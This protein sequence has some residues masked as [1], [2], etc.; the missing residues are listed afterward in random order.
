MPIA[1]RAGNGTIYGDFKGLQDGLPYLK[2]L[3]VTAVWMTP[4]HPSPAYHGYQY[5]DGGSTNPLL[6]SEAEF[7]SFVHQAHQS[8]IKVFID[9]VGYGIGGSSSYFTDAYKNPNSAYSGMFKWYDTAHSSYEGYSYQ[10]WN[11]A[12][13]SFA[14]W[15]MNDPRPAQIEQAWARKWLN[16]LYESLTDAGVDGFRLDHVV[17][18]HDNYGPNGLGYTTAQF[19]T[20][21]LQGL[22]TTYPNAKFFGEQSEWADFGNTY[23]PP[24]DATFTK[25]LEFALRD[26][27]S[28]GDKTRFVTTITQTLQ[29]LGPSQTYLATFG[30]HDVDRLTSVIGDSIPKAKL[31]AGILFAQPFAPVIY[32]GDEIGMRGLRTV[33]Y[34]SDANDIPVREPF[35]WKAIASAPMSNYYSLNS[36]VYAARF[37]RDNDGRSVEEQQLDPTSLLVMYKRLAV[38]RKGIRPLRKGQYFNLP[39]DRSD[40]LSFARVQG[41]N[42][43]VV[44][45]N[46][47]GNPVTV[48]LDLTGTNVK[49]GAVYDALPSS[50]KAKPITATSYASYQV[51]LPG[52]GLRYLLTGYAK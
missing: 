6:G 7:R 29:T 31:A 14:W 38:L 20:P 17:V 37:E 48:T 16:P 34:N 2:D 5:S 45:A 42:G 22:R 33:N 46:L 32:S 24:L 8:G 44:V 50:I 23:Q 36:A 10:S 11:G 13:V 3:G 25:P 12:G 49:T 39:S 19:W 41:G 9:F 47:S 35:K 1:W 4:I 51:S 15:D 26:T 30:D 43:V 27:L 40:V 21:M 52:Y 28:S 18:S